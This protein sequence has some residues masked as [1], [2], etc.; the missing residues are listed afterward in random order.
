MYSFCDLIYDLN[1]QNKEEIK[2]N[3][4]EQA[5]KDLSK[6]IFDILNAII[7]R[8]NLIQ[9]YAQLLHEIIRNDDQK[10][11]L[12]L[13]ILRFITR[14]SA[15]PMKIPILALLY[16]LYT[17][18]VV[19]VEDIEKYICD[20]SADPQVQNRLLVDVFIWFAPEV[21]EEYNQQ[22]FE[23]SNNEDKV[24][25]M[26]PTIQNF[27][28]NLEALGSNDF[29]L[30]RKL[31][32]DDKELKTVEAILRRDDVNLLQKVYQM[33]NFDINQ[34]V[35][36]SV[37]ERQFLTNNECP[38]ASY[39]AYY[40]SNKCLKSLIENGADLTNVD[41]NN[42]TISQFAAAGGNKET[43]D[44]LTGLV[45]FDGAAE[46]ALKYH[47]LELAKSLLDA[48]NNKNL[49]HRAASS[50]F[51][52]GIEFALQ[53]EDANAL[54]AN[55]R[56]ALM[57]ASMYSPDAGEYL[58]DKTDVNV[59]DKEGMTALMNASQN[60]FCSLVEKLLK[61]DGI[62]VNKSHRFGMTALL[63]A[64]QKNYIDVI[65]VLLGNEKVDVNAIDDENWNCLHHAVQ[66]NSEESVKYLISKHANIEHKTNDGMTPLHFAA[67]R[68]F[69][70]LVKILVESGADPNA[71][72][73]GGMTP[74]LW[75]AQTRKI[76]SIKML[77]SFEKT[78]CTICDHEQS[79]VLHWSA[80]SDFSEVIP[81]VS[82]KIDVNLRDGN[83]M[84]PILIASAFRALN[85]VSSLLALPQT[86]VSITDGNGMTI[87]H[88]AARN[89]DATLI[90]YVLSNPNFDVNAKNKSGLTA[91][92]LAAS[93]GNE[94]AVLALIKSPRIDIE[95][96]D[97][98][99]DTPIMVA[100]TF[101]YSQIVEHL[102]QSFK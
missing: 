41:S 53:T 29:R 55:G 28:F 23:I 89:D 50:G 47:H 62:E 75:A 70:G 7:Y 10:E 56:T 54:N 83:D 64:C 91:L 57:V 78:N 16:E 13:T 61:V 15:Q 25:G 35:Q 27:F 80:Q 85:F 84:P 73:N 97:N 98:D 96:K 3:V 82:S 95:A 48:G 81:L 58:A 18:N 99:G 79:N 39:C 2:K 45:S 49:V 4:L 14:R 40:G 77:L 66:T 87:L 17:I 88:Y 51:V 90:D 26:Y 31:R 67:S 100:K 46:F 22:I 44:I 43:I 24:A 71:Q 102:Q 38:L 30:L 42:V 12:I 94:D 36:P 21:S 8:P 6:C 20:Y 32:S 69:A 72:D 52:K 76:E 74:L 19:T 9:E 101:G 60:G 63:W 93:N 37:F 86:N 92:H 5:T 11:Q 68:G 59:A 33:Q 65:K 1:E 34:N